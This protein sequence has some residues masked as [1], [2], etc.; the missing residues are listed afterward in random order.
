MFYDGGDKS[1]KGIN[2]T[3]ASKQGQLANATLYQDKAQI[4]TLRQQET[5]VLN[6]SDLNDSVRISTLNSKNV[7]T[8]L[9]QKKAILKRSISADVN[10]V[11]AAKPNLYGDDVK[12][13]SERTLRPRLLT[14]AEKDDSVDYYESGM[15]M[16]AIADLYGCHYTTIVR[17]LRIKGTF[18]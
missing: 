11:K 9:T 1:L 2:C 18:A 5:P 3:T 6:G 12:M 15:S 4:R 10:L 7:K 16:V 13:V 14:S 8:A 17:I